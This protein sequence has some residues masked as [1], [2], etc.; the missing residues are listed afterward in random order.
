LFSKD[1]VS[2]SW[3]TFHTFLHISLDFS[4]QCCIFLFP[5]YFP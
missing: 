1:N 3:F 5:T 4:R 2:F